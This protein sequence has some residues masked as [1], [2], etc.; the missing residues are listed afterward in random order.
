MAATS[1]TSVGDEAP[2][3]ARSTSG[4]VAVPADFGSGSVS[5]NR[6]HRNVEQ[7]SFSEKRSLIYGGDMIVP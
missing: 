3:A 1:A 2:F 7:L 4:A 5:L 6:M